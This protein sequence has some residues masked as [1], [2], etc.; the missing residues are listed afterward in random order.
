MA[1]STAQVSLNIAANLA[2]SPSVGS[3]TATLAPA[4]SY[5]TALGATLA[6]GAGLANVGWWSTRTLT[7]SAN[8]TID[9]AGT[10]LDPFGATVTFARLKVLVI[11]ADAGNVNNVVIGGGATTLALF[12]ATTH[13]TPVRPGGV[14]MWMTGTADATGYAVASGS[15]D[16]LQIANSA[17]TTSVA[18]TIVAL[19]VAT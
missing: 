16:L 17:G 2:S 14:V 6:A 12:G 10:L 8:E 19:G 4:G 15:A 5:S 7:A 13:T 18:Y 3:A 9:F 1:L 11:A